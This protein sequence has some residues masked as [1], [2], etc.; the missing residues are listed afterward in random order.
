MVIGTDR[1][2]MFS[3]PAADI[4]FAEKET[5][6]CQGEFCYKFMFGY[7]D[8]CSNFGKDCILD[9]CLETGGTVRSEFRLDLKD[10]FP[11]FYEIFATLLYGDDGREIGI[12]EIFY[13]IS[14]WKL[15]EKWLKAAQQDSDNMLKERTANLLEINKKLRQEVH[16]RIRAEM[17]LIRAKNRSELLYRVI[18]SAIF[19]S[20]FPKLL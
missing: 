16:E 2:I 15:F 14:D 10:D 18:P 20:S 7:D 8:T 17:A 4:L 11:R 9:E 19:T 1:R 3:N 6:S 5:E 12:V 13:D